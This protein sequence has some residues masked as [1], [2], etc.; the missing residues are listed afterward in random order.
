MVA[1]HI[2][3]AL[4][5]TLYGILH[6]LLATPSFKGWAREK[7]GKNFRLYRIIYTVLAFLFFAAIIFYEVRM[8]TG[9]VFNRTNFLLATGT[10]IGASG[11]FLMFTCIQKY[12]LNMSGLRSVFSEEEA[13]VLMTQGIHRFMRHPLY[14]GTFA[15]IWGLFLVFPLWSVLISNTVIT[16]Y[17][18]V[19]I[20][21][22]EEKLVAQFGTDYT[23]YQQQVPKLI[24]RFRTNGNIQQDHRQK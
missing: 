18:L 2:L 3:L 10:L 4:S 6:S 23:R 7:L 16:V 12:F 24:P 20:G 22:E 9:A 1:N 17:T 11:L 21:L 5:W 13:P 14:T 15:F 8:E 19:G